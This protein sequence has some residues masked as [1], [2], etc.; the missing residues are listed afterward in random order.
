MTISPASTLL[1]TRTGTIADTNKGSGTFTNTASKNDD[2]SKS[3]ESIL[4]FDGK[5]TTANRTVTVNSDG[6]KSVTGTRTLANGKSVSFSE[7]ITKN[8]DGSLSIT[9][10]KTNAKGKE[11]SFTGHKTKTADG[12]SLDLGYLN[13]DGKTAEINR[14]VSISGKDRTVDVSGTG[15]NG[16]SLSDHIVYTT[17]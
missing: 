9:G 1:H 14:D 17:A 8:S 2:G 16:K 3:F 12:Y 4:S 11:I 10:T 7:T 13:S 15:L 6:S 5:S